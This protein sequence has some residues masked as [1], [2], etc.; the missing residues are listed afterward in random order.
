LL[1]KIPGLRYVHL[2]EG[3]LGATSLSRDDVRK[4]RRS[5]P[6]CRVEL[7]PRWRTPPRFSGGPIS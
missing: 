4:I 2:N 6:D 7:E 1:T 3:E 5:M